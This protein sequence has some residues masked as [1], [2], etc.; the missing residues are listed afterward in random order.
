[1]LIHG[2]VSLAFSD[3]ARMWRKRHNGALPWDHA[4][5]VAWGRENSIDFAIDRV[6]KKVYCTPAGI[7]V[8]A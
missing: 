3:M 1:M 7:S 6:T 4:D 2:C 5:A 8:P